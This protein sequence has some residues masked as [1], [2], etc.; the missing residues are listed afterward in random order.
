MN[1]KTKFDRKGENNITMT[2]QII[3]SGTYIPEQVISNDDLAKFV[4]TSDS[5]IVE[6]TG[7]SNR[8]CTSEKENVTSM[9][10]KAARKALDKSGIAADEIDLIIVATSSTEQIYP[11]AACQVQDA[12]AAGNAVCFDLNAACSG[13]VFAYNTALS[14][15]MTG[16]ARYALIIGAEQMTRLLD[17]TDRSTCILFGDGAGAVLI[18]AKEGKMVLPKMHSNGS[19]GEA[20]TCQV[21]GKIGMNGQEVFCF[22]VRQV[23]RVIEELL[24]DA[25]LKKE[26]IDYYLVHQA[27]VRI[28]EAIAKKLGVSLEKFP[29]NLKEYGNT[30]SA[31]IPILLDECFQNGMIKRGMRLVIAGFGAGLSWGATLI[32]Y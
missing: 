14:Y 17:F 27:N 2:G 9:A 19:K 5:W 30:S 13:F 31:S 8:H 12:L 7:I 29:M 1:N 18:K 10:I 3:A 11:A 15:L 26:E 20:L 22:A 16:M 6:R 32:E 4:D 28:I 21:N 23:P 25:D 24:L